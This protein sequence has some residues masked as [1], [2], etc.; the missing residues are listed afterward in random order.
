MEL[1]LIPVPR[2]QGR[3]HGSG[4][5]GLG[6]EGSREWIPLQ[7]KPS[8]EK[9]E[10]EDLGFSMCSRKCGIDGESGKR[11]RSEGRMIP[12]NQRILVGGR[13]IPRN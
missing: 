1:S 4:A 11:I 12:R 10:K 7:A 2:P 8:L 5:A 9:R 13:M 3:N 6:K